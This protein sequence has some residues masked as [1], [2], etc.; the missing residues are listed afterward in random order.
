MQGFSA[1]IARIHWRNQLFSIGQSTS[2]RQTSEN[3]HLPL[4]AYVSNT[5]LRS[6]TTLKC[7]TTFN[8]MICQVAHKIKAHFAP[9]TRTAKASLYLFDN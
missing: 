5:M 7:N 8:E 6:T 3:C 1:S 9:A 2:S 4:K